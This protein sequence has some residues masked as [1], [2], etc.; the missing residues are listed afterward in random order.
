MSIAW[1]EVSPETKLEPVLEAWPAAER[2]LAAASPS[3]RALADPL[4]RRTFARAATLRQVA[5]AAGVSVE[6]LLRSIERAIRFPDE[7]L[8]VPPRGD[9]P[10]RPAWAE[11][12]PWARHDARL[13]VERGVHPL[14]EVIEELEQ[15]PDGEVYE[16]LTPLVP[17]PLLGLL[18]RKGFEAFWTL[19]EE[20]G[21]AR[22]LIR[23]APA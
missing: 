15:L 11:A 19:D 16:L 3:F 18:A 20:R 22:T 4:L 10:H 21:F 12:L 8:E 14:P 5:Q 6:A 9:G 1:A 13:D 17:A 2:V 23:R 7:P